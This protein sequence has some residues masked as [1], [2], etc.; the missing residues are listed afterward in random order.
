MNE[1]SNAPIQIHYQNT[2]EDWMRLV[3]AYQ[4]Q[5]GWRQR[6]GPVL[7]LQAFMFVCC[8]PATLVLMVMGAWAPLAVGL[9][10]VGVLNVFIIAAMRRTSPPDVRILRPTTLTLHPDFLEVWTD[11]GGERRDWSL[12]T[13]VESV[14]DLFVMHRDDGMVYTVPQRAFSSAAQAEQFRRAAVQY[15]QDATERAPLDQVAPWQEVSGPPKVVSSDTLQV[16]FTASPVEIQKL[17]TAGVLHPVNE[18]PRKTA[19]GTGWISM[20][21]AAIAIILV[22]TNA[23]M[24]DDREIG[25]LESF[26]IF[27]GLGALMIWPSFRVLQYLMRRAQKNSHAVT[28]TITVS[29]TGVS[30]WAPGIEARSEWQTVDMVQ[31]NSHVIVFAAHRPVLVHWVE[32]PKSAFADDDE[33]RRFAQTAALYRQAAAERLEETEPSIAPYADT[34]NPYQ[35]PQSR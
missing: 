26:F 4:D 15:H 22:W 9:L 25:G 24:L 30:R 20:L 18:K 3:K 34:G 10:L 33:A 28:Q 12:I 5:Q 6:W 32:I 14:D 7:V 19:G 2:V 21:F 1:P 13:K 29:P 16:S 27:L 23:R 8:L 35:P 11:Q 31:E 17:V